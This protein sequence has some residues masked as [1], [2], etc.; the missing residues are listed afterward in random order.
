MRR[1]SAS[2]HRSFRNGSYSSRTMRSPKWQTWKSTERA[3]GSTPMI[4][5]ITASAPP[6]LK[7]LDSSE[8]S[9]FSREATNDSQFHVGPAI[10]PNSCDWVYR[11]GG[12]LDFHLDLPLA[13]EERVTDR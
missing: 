3:T 6:R 7:S 9:K 5:S 12:F 10:P 1:K 8:A 2:S 11:S 13:T 4:P